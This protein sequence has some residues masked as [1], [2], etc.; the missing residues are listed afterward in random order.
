MRSLFPVAAA[1]PKLE[2]IIVEGASELKQL[3]GGED[4][5]AVGIFEEKQ[6]LLP[7]LWMLDLVQLLNHITYCPN[8][9]QL[10]VPK[11]VSSILEECQLSV[12]AKA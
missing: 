11:L 8:G 4:Q 3:V 7:K 2:T 10:E 6:I 12:N 1:L 9:Y 5:E